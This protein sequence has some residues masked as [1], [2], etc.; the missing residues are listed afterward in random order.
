MDLRRTIRG[1]TLQ[2][3]FSVKTEFFKELG[4]LISP[5]RIHPKSAAP[6]SPAALLEDDQ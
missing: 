4:L 6:G 2:Y 5:S 1:T 3:L